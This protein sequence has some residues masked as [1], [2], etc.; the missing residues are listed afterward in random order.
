MPAV[1]VFDAA[2]ALSPV[3][4]LSSEQ[5]QR[6][7][8]KGTMKASE[9]EEAVK[10]EEE[11]G[12]AMQGL[13]RVGLGSLA[14]PGALDVKMEVDGEDAKKP[15]RPALKRELSDDPAA[16]FPTPN[17][18]PFGSSSSS[19]AF[20]ASPT[21]A[22]SGIQLPPLPDFPPLTPPV[23]ST[24]AAQPSHSPSRQHDRVAIPLDRLVPIGTLLL[25]GHVID[26][27][28]SHT[29]AEDDWFVYSKDTLKPVPPPGV[30]QDELERAENDP[31][32]SPSPSAPSTPRSPAKKSKK[33]P[34]PLYRR[35][36]PSKRAK[37]A[38]SASSSAQKSQSLLP[39]LDSLTGAVALRATV[40]VDH[41]AEEPTAVVR[42]YL[43]PQD[44]DELDDP[45]YARGKLKRPGASTVFQVLEAVRIRRE[46]WEGSAQG[47]DVQRFMDEKDTRSLLEVYRDIESPRRDDVWIDELDAPTEVKDRLRWALVE[48]AECIQTEMFPY[49]KA[50]LAKMLARELAP[51]AIPSP[52]YIA[53]NSLGNEAQ[54][55]Y[56]S[57]DGSVRL[58]PEKVVEPRGGILA[59]DMGV[60]KTLITLSLVLSTLNELPKLDET[61]TYL[62]HSLPSPSPNLLTAVSLEFPFPNEIAEAKRLRPRVPE[63][64]AGYIMAEKE[65]EEYLAAIA[66]QDEE[67]RRIKTFPLPSLR[68]LMIHHIKTTPTAIRYSLD[69]VV[70]RETGVLDVLQKSPPFYRVFPSPAQLDS[71]EGRKGRFQP[72]EVVVA[73]TTLIVVPTD[74]VRQWND[75]IAKHVEPGTLRVLTL[76]TAKDKFKSAAEFATYDLVL[77]SVAR[78]AD[79]AEAND[80]SLRG[81]HWKRL[82]VDEGHTLSSANRMRKLAEELRCESRWAVSGTPSTNLRGAQEGAEGALFG[83][84]TKAGGDRVDLDRLGH[85]FSRFVKHAALPRFDMLRKV[86]QS[87]VFGGGERAYRLK[88]ILDRSVIRHH[89]SHVQESFTLPPLTKRVV[90]VEMEEAERR[91]YNALIALFSSNSITSQKVDVDYLFHPSKAKHLSTICDNLGVST[92]FF[93]SSEFT[94]QLIEARDYAQRRLN[95]ESALK[96]T[97]DERQG[98]RKALAVLQEAIDDREL[99]LTSGAPGLGVEVEDFPSDL[100]SPFLG[101]SASRSALGRVLLSQSQ[102]VRLKVN[103]KEL[104]RAD[105]KEWQDDEEL[106]EE[107][108]TFEDRRKRFDAAAAKATTAALQAELE[109]EEPIFKKRN[110]KE[111]LATP[112]E[113]LPEDSVLKQI[114]LVRTTSSKVNHIIGELRKYPDD[115]FIVFCSS[116]VD[117]VFSNLSET[118]DLL[119]IRHLIF[120]GHSTR[121]QD[122]GLTAHKFNST[123][124]EECQVILVDAKLGGRG[125]TLTAANRVILTEP[126]WK[127]DLEVQAIKRAHRLGQKKPV[128]VQ[129]LVVEHSYEDALLK[130]RGQVAPEDFAKR[131]KL[132]QQDGKLRELLQAAKYLEP[133]AAAREGRAVSGRME[134]GV[135]LIRD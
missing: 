14:R 37:L 53:R 85:L 111:Q 22:F 55:V 71:R 63:P 28:V 21:G 113:P 91:V 78:F 29:V 61:S 106:I 56:V 135:A 74:L 9:S 8:L 108:I 100:M 81:V 44:L 38:S 102:L 35:S 122:R 119:G 90:H 10:Q 48:G 34:A 128:D 130:R 13:K 15:P 80:T 98:L 46:E 59:E 16:A 83:S 70:L 129:I 94:W 6:R 121:S 17:S 69:D 134:P 105:V 52:S 45:K 11:D 2:M 82:V 86:V 18:T 57:L 54:T 89:H 123:T 124:A 67:D 64:L 79:A 7:R 43:V 72:A 66:K 115:K 103:L 88:G 77:C 26:E 20:P 125:F 109:A 36:S 65:E 110:K 4:Q 131:V 107:M 5:E 19:F 132:P 39:A 24:S 84:T 23:A 62:D 104:R 112:I 60:G 116:N 41:S 120:A 1:T 49:Q 97:E 27:H 33:R 101:L 75:E 76:R 42:V 127:A 30:E 87:H 114:R 133:A 118:L 99:Q 96:W 12:E 92:T 73:A 32:P 25:P 50:T 47:E 58:E 95:G 40:R 51:Q 31:L 68:S 126:I 93:G 117:L 3:P